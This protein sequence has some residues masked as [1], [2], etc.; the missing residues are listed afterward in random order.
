MPAT[1]PFI[2]SLAGMTD[3]ALQFNLQEA[4][5]TRNAARYQAIQAE[6]ARRA[7]AKREYGNRVNRGIQDYRYRGVPEGINGAFPTPRPLA[8]GGMLNAPMN[9]VRGALDPATMM[10]LMRARPGM[11]S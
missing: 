3:Q 6:I 4:L 8:P 11:L 2:A 10:A 5:D 7:E 9:G 1:D